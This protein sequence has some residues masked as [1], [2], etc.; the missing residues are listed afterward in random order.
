MKKDYQLTLGNLSCASCVARAERAAL[1]VSEVEQFTVNLATRQGHL[2]LR[3]P[4]AYQLVIQSLERAGYPAV[5]TLQN[6]VDAEKV[7]YRE[8]G[9]RWQWAAA[10]SLPL[11]IIEM[12]RHLFPHWVVVPAAHQDDWNVL[13]WLLAS[14]VLFGP[15][16]GIFVLGAKSI[17]SRAPDMHALVLSGA[18]A[19]Y[20]FS[21]VVWITGKPYGLYF[22]AA[23][24]IC[25]LIL[26]GH[27][28]EHGAR[29]RAGEAIGSLMALSPSTA[30]RWQNGS[31]IECSV[32]DVNTGDRLQVLPGESLPADGNLLLDAWVDEGLLTGESEAL[33]RTQGDAVTGGSLNAGK[34]ALE[35]TATATGQSTALAGIIAMV[36]AAQAT[37]L[38]VQAIINRVTLWFVPAILVLA[39]SSTAVWLYLSDI[40]T[41]LVVGVSVLIIACPCAMGLATPTSIMV[42]MGRAAKLG[43]LFRQGSAIERLS[44]VKTLAFDKT[45]TLTLGQT[46]LKHVGALADWSPEDLRRIAAGLEAESSHPIAR[47]LAHESPESMTAIESHVAQGIKGTDR[48]GRSWF[49]GRIA[50]LEEMV[51]SPPHSLPSDTADTLVGLVC[52]QTWAGWFQVADPIKPDAYKALAEL[53]RRGIHLVMLSGDRKEVAQAVG[54]KLDFD[55]IQAELSPGDKLAALNRLPGPVGF[56]GD[57]INDAPALAKADVGLAIGTGTQVAVDSSDVVLMGERLG[58]VAQAHRISRATLCNIRQN[59]FWAFGYNVLLIPVAMGLFGFFLSPMLAAGAMAL[60]SVCVVTNALRLRW[61]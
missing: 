28:L 33:L 60:S 12:G 55:E 45:G 53:K 52:E 18:G 54:E 8:L 17:K 59:L 42:G 56:V 31:W 4:S 39:V 20:V 27:W 61:S 14:A 10:L 46:E 3:D 51:G 19:A 37:R 13:Q 5:A 44:R 25:T 15:A 9:K 1:A 49:L 57:G 30:R 7:E 32:N 50:W 24:V 47:A 11:L 23:A 36:A 48:Q 29:G 26:L 43:V 58:T 21:T 38:P 41:A 16:R 6:P 2:V 35:F 22:E 40:E 34:Q